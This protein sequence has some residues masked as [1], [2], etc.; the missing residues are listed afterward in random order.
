MIDFDEKENEFHLK[1]HNLPF[2]LYSEGEWKNAKCYYSFD[3]CRL[4]TFVCE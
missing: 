2:E 1:F 3:G 4:W